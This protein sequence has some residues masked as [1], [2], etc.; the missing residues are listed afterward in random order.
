MVAIQSG[1]TGT[2]KTSSRRSLLDAQADPLRGAEDEITNRVR[3]AQNGI[4]R[5]QLQANFGRFQSALGEP[6]A[7]DPLALGVQSHCWWNVSTSGN[8]RSS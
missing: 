1:P 4:G 5:F 2:R 6:G 8:P 7:V 3:I